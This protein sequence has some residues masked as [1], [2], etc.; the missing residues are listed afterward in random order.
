MAPKVS[1]VIPVYNEA[2]I[3][4]S[5]AQ[6]L[7]ESLG[8]TDWDWE[9]LFAE[10]GSVDSTPEIL[11]GLS[12]T[13][14]RIRFLH[15][16]EPNYGRALRR[17]ILESRGDFVIC[18]EIDLC[19]ATFHLDAMRILL[20]GEAEMVVGSKAAPGA[21]DE[22]PVVRRAGTKVL[23]GL[24]RA[25]LGY[26]G[27]DT[28]GLKA[29]RREALLPAANACKVERDLFASEF[30]VRAYRMGAKVKE[31]PVAIREK[32]RPSVHLFRRVPNVLKNLARL[33]WVIRIQGE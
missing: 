28:H 23:N 13:D 33:V 29:F 30:V 17:G 21:R 27:T 5:A 8:K 19:D 14:P 32:R 25:A 9:I 6:E 4:G 12:R 31:I 3:L 22:R 1:V 16:A 20:A 11:D 24:L 2:A 15:E 10:N 7:T 18:E 26:R